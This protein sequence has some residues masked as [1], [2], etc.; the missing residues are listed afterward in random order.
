MDLQNK[1]V[2][3]PELKILFE[4]N[5]ILV[6]EKPVN[7]PTQADKTGDPDLL[8]IIQSLIRNRDQKEGKV[9]IGLIHRLDRPVGGL[10]VFAKTPKAASILAEQL[11]SKTIR[12]A[13]LTTV[14]GCPNETEAELRHFLFKIEKLNFSKVVKPIHTGGKEAVLN[15]KL[16]QTSPENYSLLKVEL[17]TGR[18]HQIRV[19]LSAIGNPIFGDQK[20]GKNK[21]NSGQQLAL[22]AYHLS[23]QHPIHKTEMA[24]I[25]MPPEIFPWKLFDKIRSNKIE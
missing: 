18:H 5:H 14:Y 12:K 13:Y 15:Y 17:H 24:F 11:R 1:L 22:W 9:Y 21:S 4:D 10:V 2:N 19:Q 6:V 8:S 7:I 16:I 25:S 23:F 20:Y 3:I